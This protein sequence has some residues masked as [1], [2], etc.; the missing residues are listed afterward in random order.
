MVAIK[1]HVKCFKSQKQGEKP[2]CIPHPSLR[3]AAAQSRAKRILDRTTHR[4]TETPVPNEIELFEALHTC[5][6]W[7]CQETPPPGHLRRQRATWLDRWRRIR[8]YIV[9]SNL[10]LVH[11]LV[12][13][14]RP[15]DAER[16]EM[17][18][19]ATMALLRA[20]DRYNPWYG[21]RFSTFASNCIIHACRH[22][23]RLSGAAFFSGLGIGR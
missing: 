23:N 13:R 15:A 11:A 6:F 9:E 2:F 22:C 1:H 4:T 16:D 5:A 19:S 10:G 3:T 14:F 21:Y 12:R 20:V 17:I 7:A 8:A 18:S